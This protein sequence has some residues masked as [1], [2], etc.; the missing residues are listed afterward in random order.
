MY[1]AG[2]LKINGSYMYKVNIDLTTSYGCHGSILFII[3]ILL[4]LNS[5]LQKELT[6][7]K[8]EYTILKTEH[9]SVLQRLTHGKV[10]MTSS[11][12]PNTGLILTI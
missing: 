2:G 9:R 11:I 4:E 3:Y 5:S 12:S 8:E 7:S 10:I 6:E 1:Y